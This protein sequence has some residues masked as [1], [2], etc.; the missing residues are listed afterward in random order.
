M[1]RLRTTGC[2]LRGEERNVY[3]D[4]EI[5]SLFLFQP[6]HSS[7]KNAGTPSVKRLFYLMGKVV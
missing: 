4:E 5:L 3:F 1:G 2:R 6:E 7:E